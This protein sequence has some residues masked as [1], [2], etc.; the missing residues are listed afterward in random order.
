MTRYSVGY[1]E[2]TIRFFQE[3]NAHTH[4]RFLLDYLVAGMDLLDC[5][6]GPGTIT[7]GLAEIV[8]PGQVVGVDIDESQIAHAQH[9][10]ESF[11]PIDFRTDDLCS[12]SSDDESF[13]V[14]FVHGVLEHMSDP[15]TAISEIYR[16]LRSGGLAGSRHADFGGF[17]LEPAGEPLAKFPQLFIQLM[18]QNGGDPYFGRQ[19]TGLFREAG[20]EILRVS[21]SYDCWTSDAACTRRN[22]H[23]LSELC[24]DSEFSTQLVE[25]GLTDR[26]TLD[27]LKTSFLLWAEMS[28]AF[29][30]EAWGEVVVRKP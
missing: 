25:Y 8:T 14:V 28:E 3:R 7:R 16:V 26:R 13:D 23:F 29:A 21:A 15:K 6:C 27:H 19:Q 18:K 2:R 11:P 24:G 10:A 1:D 17:L 30:A 12:L 9:S 5:G 4:A 20:F 22:A